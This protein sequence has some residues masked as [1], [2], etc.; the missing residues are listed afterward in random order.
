LV[1]AGELALNYQLTVKPQ[2]GIGKLAEVINVY[3]LNE[4]VN[5]ETRDD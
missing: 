1:N 5:V 4:G 2:N 3:Y